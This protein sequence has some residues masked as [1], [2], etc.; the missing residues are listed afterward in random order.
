M[1]PLKAF[2]PATLALEGISVGIAGSV[3]EERIF[4]KWMGV[5]HVLAG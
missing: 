2:S 3:R 1:L 5:F 4:V